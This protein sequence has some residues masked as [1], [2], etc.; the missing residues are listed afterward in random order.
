MEIATTIDKARLTPSIAEILAGLEGEDSPWAVLLCKFSDDSSEVA[1]R[2]H[3]ERLFT[4]AANGSSNMVDFFRD[5]S[6]GS[7]NL[8]RS[9]VFGWYTLSI[10]KA[11]YAGNV[12]TPP[13]GQVNRGGLFDLCKQKASE[14]GVD[15]SRFKG[16]VV[17]MAGQVDLFGFLGGM[18]AM[19]DSLS[20]KPSLL[21]QEMGH[22]YGLDHAR[23]DGSNEEYA[24]PWD[25]MS[26]A[27][28][29]MAEGGEYELTGPAL[30]A[31]NMRSRGWLD[32]TRV[33]RGS[34]SSSAATVELRPLHRRDLPGLLAAELG[35]YLVE[36]RMKEN[37]DA[38]IPRSC[39]LVHRFQDNHSYVMQ[40]TGRN[41]DLVA[42]DS[43]RVG[44]PGA[45]ETS[46]A[47]V[48]GIDEGERIATIK[49]AHHP[50]PRPPQAGP[51]VV[52]GGVPVDGPG[53]IVIGGKFH[54]VPP[55]G[56]LT[57]ILEQLASFTASEQ[58]DDV[59]ARGVSQRAALGKIAQHALVEMSQNEAGL[60]STEE[61]PDA[62][63]L[64]QK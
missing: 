56:P 40:G 25:V 15:L 21:G 29:Y 52:I 11:A 59:A 63:L 47:E 42:G 50:A 33:W 32:E 16:V 14:E 4:R 12:P 8:G 51:G 62:K 46:E 57:G 27:N 26:T 43:F 22:G 49:L 61:R 10:D 20:L 54:P 41:Y 38:P 2:E 18:G 37:W 31:A 19:C 55:R 17:S 7:L 23:R 9:E 28:A 34:S 5:V 64:E 24:D 35:P 36:F 39:V 1:P 53:G 48:V 13:P 3:Y 44:I 30:N 6:H 45:T 58:I 60:P